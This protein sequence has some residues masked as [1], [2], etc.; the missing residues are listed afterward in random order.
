MGIWPRLLANKGDVMAVDRLVVLGTGGTIAGQA[1]RPDDTVGYTAGVVPVDALLA[2]VALPGGWRVTCEQVAQVDSKDMGPLV[3]RALL[4]RVAHHL[5]QPDVG[6]LVITHG[7]D[8]LEETAYLVQ[9]VLN[10]AKPVVLTCAMR[11]ASAPSPDGPL[12]LA[13]ALRVASEPGARGVVVVCAGRIHGALE[14]QKVHPYRL[15][16]FDSGDAGVVGCLEAGQVRLWRPWPD[17]AQD[18]DAGLLT[19]LLASQDWP[20]VVWVTNHGGNDGLLVRSL[21]AAQAAGRQD[22]PVAGVVV[23]GTGNGSL[24]EDLASALQAAQAAGLTVWVTTRCAQGR[25]LPHGRDD[26]LWTRTT[27]PPAKAR[28]ALMLA[29]V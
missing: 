18:F 7:T 10:P 8:T 19:R 17:L 12:N 23:A 28:L 3:W 25:V 22:R 24:H 15:D 21:L 1:S 5:A 20:R 9:A 4:G 27:L 2:R 29:L 11:P 16:P 26:R 13:D 6:G 14:V